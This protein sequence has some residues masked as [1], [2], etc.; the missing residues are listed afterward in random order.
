MRQT[1]SIISAVN[2]GVTAGSSCRQP[3]QVLV[4]DLVSWPKPSSLT[5]LNS[6]QQYLPQVGVTAL[7]HSQSLWDTEIPR[8]YSSVWPEFH[9]HSSLSRLH[10]SS[11][12][13]SWPGSV[14]PAKMVNPL[15]LLVSKIQNASREATACSSMGPLLCSLVRMNFPWG[16]EQ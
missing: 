12:T 2:L 10:N 13:P 5:G 1:T 6:W 11:P 9:A 16:S 8:R 14:T 15:C 3:L 4:I 7:V